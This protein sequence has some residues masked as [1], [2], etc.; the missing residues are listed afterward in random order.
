MIGLSGPTITKSEK[1]FIRRVQPAGVIYFRRNVKTPKQLRALSRSV[2]AL[3]P[4]DH[5]PFIG[6]DQEGGRVARLGAPFTVFPGNRALG[7][8]YEKTG[9][10]SW[11]RFQAGAMASELRSIGVNLNFTPVA[12]I[13]SNP[14]NP[15]IGS[16]SF[17]KDPGTVS[18]L[19]L[20][21][22]GAYRS[23]GVISCAKHFPGHGDT[24]TDS[25]KVLPTVKA[26][27]QTLL[28]RELVPFR[29]A[30][31]SGIPAIMTAHVIYRGLDAKRTATLSPIIMDQ[32]LRR[33]FRFKGVLISDDLEMS[34]IAAHR[35][36]ADAAVDAI[37]AGV[38][39]L[40]VCSSLKEAKSVHQRLKKAVRGE[41]LSLRRVQSALTRIASLRRKY[42]TGKGARH[43]GPLPKSGW[44]RHQRLA[45]KIQDL[46]LGS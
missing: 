4:K 12:D 31:A 46:S 41:E 32:L 9:K 17:G 20:A 44:P 14:K 39:L 43:W 35:S 33:K 3:Y 30:I 42:V 22:T 25:H 26:S 6:I 15:I 27:S 1:I 29:K 24:H 36:I 16:R 19:V 40:L 37:A 18:K 38:D 21:T 45:A 34:A 2:R 13:D 8:I 5:L 11:A 28:R 7:Q 23:S 10:T